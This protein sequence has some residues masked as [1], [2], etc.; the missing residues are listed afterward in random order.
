ME[1]IVVDR[2]HNDLLQQAIAA[3]AVGLA[4]YLWLW[5]TVV[6]TTWRTA[7]ARAHGDHGLRR[8]DD[9][10]STLVDPRLLAAGLL[11]GFVAYLAQLQLSFSYVSVAPL[12]WLLVGLVAALRPRV[13]WGD[14]RTFSR[15]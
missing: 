10:K 12:F 6:R 15:G 2:P 3:G 8:G 14:S 7:R 13:A 1:H 9:R 4:A 11:G 5:Y